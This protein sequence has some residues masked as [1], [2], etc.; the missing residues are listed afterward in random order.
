M[1]KISQLGKVKRYQPCNAKVKNH[2]LKCI[3]VQKV[4]LWFYNASQ[5]QKNIMPLCIVV[6]NVVL[7]FYHAPQGKEESCMEDRLL[8]AK[9]HIMNINFRLKKVNR[10]KPCNYALNVLSFKRAG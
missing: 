5:R 1:N 8:N 3:V 2:A 4:V 7:K 10:Y 6:L 9:I